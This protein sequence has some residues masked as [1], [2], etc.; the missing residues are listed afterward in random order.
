MDESDANSTPLCK[1]KELVSMTLEQLSG[2]FSGCVGIIMRIIKNT[3]DHAKNKLEPEP[4]PFCRCTLPLHFSVE[5]FV[6]FGAFSLEPSPLESLLVEPLQQ[7]PSPSLEPSPLEP[8]L[9]PSPLELSV[10]EFV[11]GVFVAI[12]AFAAGTFAGGA[13]SV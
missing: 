5:V 6:V 7:E 10:S 12:G 13:S 8:L 2:R 3:R 1:V 4:L 11:V 9:Q